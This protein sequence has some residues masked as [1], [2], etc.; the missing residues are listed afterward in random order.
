MEKQRVSPCSARA[1]LLSYACG[2]K[3]TH[4]GRRGCGRGRSGG[5]GKRG[6]TA[7]FCTYFSAGSYV[8]AGTL[9]R[10]HAAARGHTCAGSPVG[11]HL[12][13][14]SKKVCERERQTV[15]PLACEIFS[16]VG[17]AGGSAPTAPAGTPGAQLG[18]AGRCARFGHQKKIRERHK[19][20]KHQTA[21]P[22]LR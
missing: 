4:A 6:K 8:H 13:P 22:S 12:S 18:D 3:I 2:V 16:P 17:F 5:I 20:R 11:A 10:G 7:N 14:R 15:W 9:G 1:G 19:R 21:L